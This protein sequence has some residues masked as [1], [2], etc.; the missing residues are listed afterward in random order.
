M[1]N[2]PSVVLW[3]L[4]SAAVLALSATPGARQP[5]VARSAIVFIGDGVDDHQLTI[6]RNY[7]RGAPVLSGTWRYGAHADG[8]AL[9]GGLENQR[10][11]GLDC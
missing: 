3:G 2:V 5:A 4:A 9:S 10:W 7:L 8:P 6:A 11:I 1:R